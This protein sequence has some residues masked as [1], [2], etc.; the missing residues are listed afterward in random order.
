MLM[1]G[2]NVANKPCMAAEACVRSETVLVT[3]FPSR[4]DL[5][6]GYYVK[7]HNLEQ[8]TGVHSCH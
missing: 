1:A 4:I 6:H 3:C 2:R 7:R 8:G 5:R